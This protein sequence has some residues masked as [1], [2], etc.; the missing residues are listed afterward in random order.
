MGGGA[1]PY[2]AEVGVLGVEHPDD[3]FADLDIGG[4]G[5]RVLPEEVAQLGFS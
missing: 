2:K 1:L 4:G 5:G 3:G